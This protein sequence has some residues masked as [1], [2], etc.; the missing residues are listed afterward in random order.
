[1]LVER[2]RK[3]LAWIREKYDKQYLRVARIV[4][5]GSSQRQESFFLLP[6]RCYIHAMR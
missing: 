4:R 2:L 6:S 5:G 3:E 1:M